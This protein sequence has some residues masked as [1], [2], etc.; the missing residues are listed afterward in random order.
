[1]S[2]LWTLIGVAMLAL[3]L[4]ACGGGGGEAEN[5][6]TAPTN[7]ETPTTSTGTVTI[8][9]W[10]SETAANE[11]AI[12]DLIGRF[13]ASQDEVRVNLV[14]QGSTNDLELKLF[15]SLGSD[16]VPALV[17]LVEW[18]AG[19]MIDSRS[20]TPVQQFV[21][22]EGYDLSDFDEAALD[23]YRVA[24]E[25]YAMPMGI[26]VPML[27]Y[28]KLDFEEVGLDPDKPPLTLE[29]VRAYSEKLYKEDSAGNVVRSGIALDTNPFYLRAALA[30]RNELVINNNNGYDGRATEAVFDNET[31]RD[32]FQFW[33]DMVQDSLAYN[34]GLNPSGAEALLAIAAGRASMAFT[35]SSALGPAIDV[36]EGGLEGV[37]P[38]AGPFPG[39]TAT[40]EA[41]VYARSLWIMSDRPEKEQQAAWKLIRWLVEPEQQAGWFAGT[42]YLPVRLSAYDLPASHQVL[43][44]YPEYQVPIDAFMGTPSTPAKLG[45]RSGAFPTIEQ[46]LRDALEAVIL[47]QQN[48]EDA[49][50]EAA[51]DTTE[52]LQNYNRRVE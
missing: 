7:G 49:L 21:D 48:A 45:P 8:D 33:G 39:G 9:F 51:A 47:G 24:D 29:D 22:A 4:V 32:I 28:N 37:E 13:N 30:E 15:A 50:R 27:F 36:I 44:K 14:Y 5:G 34:V 41:G 25:L 17:E 16:D 12:T 46:T 26:I 18:E 11:D 42:G 52:E 19:I 6:G 40:G 35:G 38:G 10:H 2:R 43:Q 1:M 23:Q 3:A 20:V 31:S